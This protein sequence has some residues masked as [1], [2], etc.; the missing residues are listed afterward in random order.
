MSEVDIE[1]EPSQMDVGEIVL[2][3]TDDEVLK[4]LFA[5]EESE[6]AEQ[7]QQQQKQGMTRTAATRTVGTRPTGG[8]GKVGGAP[9]GGSRSDVDSLTSLWPSAPDVREAFNMR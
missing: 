9:V 3:S 4:T 8:V 1:M 5:N 6:Q 7:A 2:S